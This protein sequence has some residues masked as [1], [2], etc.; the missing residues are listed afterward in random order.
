[1]TGCLPGNLLDM[2]EVDSA[3]RFQAGYPAFPL[4]GSFGFGIPLEALN[5][6]L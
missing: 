5:L 4:R 6:Y 3:G 1:M 2:V